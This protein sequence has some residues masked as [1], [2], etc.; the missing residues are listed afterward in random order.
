MKKMKLLACLLALAT[1]VGTVS[2]L[3]APGFSLGLGVQYWD[4]EDA[5]EFDKDGMWGGSVIARVRPIDYFGIDFRAGGMGIWDSKTYRI[6][7]QKYETDAA[8]WC[9]PF[10]VGLL[11]MLPV[12][13]VFTI[14]GGPGVGYYYYDIDIETTTKHGH[15]W[16]SERSD[17]IKL[18]DDFG[19]YAV[20]GAKF[21][22]APCFSIFGEARYTDTETSFKDAKSDKIDCSGFGVQVGCMFDF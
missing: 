14:Y 9:C 10:E 20:A 13:D 18:D 16:H 19:W 3:G 11:L 8:F 12:S 2:A 17:H 1:A 6:N 21:Q 5:S 7:G 22:F 4:A 15:H